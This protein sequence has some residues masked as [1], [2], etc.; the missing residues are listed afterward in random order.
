MYTYTIYARP[1]QLRLSTD[2]APSFV[3]ASRRRKRLIYN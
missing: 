3:T 2:H 1:S